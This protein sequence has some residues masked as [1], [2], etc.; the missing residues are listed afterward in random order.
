MVYELVNVDTLYSGISH[1]YFTLL[2]ASGWFFYMLLLIQRRLTSLELL[3]ERTH[4][5]DG[6][7]VHEE[8]EVPYEEQVHALV[9]ERKEMSPDEEFLACIGARTFSSTPQNEMIHAHTSNEPRPDYSY[10][11][12]SKEG[13]YATF[14]SLRHRGKKL[15]PDVDIPIAQ[16]YV[17]VAEI[18]RMRNLP[19]LESSQE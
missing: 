7:Q 15:E 11:H 2:I 18:T 4:E 1:I 17:N 3:I 12:T 8:E 9:E 14:S 5:K 6:I 16:G 10:A 13:G 19:T